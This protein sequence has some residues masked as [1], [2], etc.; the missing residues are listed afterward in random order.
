LDV[1]DLASG[2][3]SAWILW[4]DG[5]VKVDEA[6]RSASAISMP[7]QGGLLGLAVGDGAAWVRGSG[8]V[9]VDART[10]D[11]RLSV[12]GVDPGFGL[13]FG[14]G[15]IWMLVDQPAARRFRV[16]S[17]SSS[18]GDETDRKEFDGVL[19]TMDVGEDAI[20]V[21]CLRWGSDDSPELHQFV[22]RLD[23][24]TLNFVEH[25]ISMEEMAHV[26]GSEIW[27]APHT[28][29]HP[30]LL[31]LEPVRRVDP[32]TWAEIGR[33]GV[34]GLLRHLSPHRSGLWGLLDGIEG[35]TKQVCEIEREANRVIAVLDLAD[36][37]ARPFLPPPPGPIDPG[38]V[39]QRLRDELAEYLLQDP[40]SGPRLG[41]RTML[42][43]VLE[44]VAFENVRLEGAFPYTEVVILF[45]TRRRPEILFG[46]RERIW[47][48]E[49]LFASDGPTVI[50]T[51]LE[52]TITFEPGLPFHAEP[53][54]T[55]VVWV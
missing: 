7:L 15:R 12:E 40:I 50:V 52:E 33:I 47:S 41:R 53:D 27:L 22:I 8:I 16:L 28:L 18:S 21:R 48:D 9:R 39:E 34:P 10:G 1:R 55:G 43:R 3:G 20:W 35:S 54:V 11:A 5:L 42:R 25:E 32:A 23:P 36:V 49:G 6:A 51:N 2:E 4:P 13:W 29:P 31:P 19:P 46:W 26:V 38:P 24:A 37:D 17:Y 45:R 14:H 44:T 30:E